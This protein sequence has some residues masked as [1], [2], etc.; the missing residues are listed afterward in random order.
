MFVPTDSPYQRQI[1]LLQALWREQNRFPIGE[2]RGPKLGSRLPMPWARKSLANYLTP[3][4]GRIVAYEYA[5]RHK[6]RKLYGFPRLFDDLLSSQPLCF[7]LFG[8]LKADLALASSVFAELVPG[9]AKVVRLEFEHS[10]GRGDARFSGD[11]SA[12][13][14]YV[15]YR[16]AEGA[17]GFI[18][19]EVKYHEDLGNPPAPHR[20]RYDEVASGMGCFLAE[21]RSLLKGKPLQQ[22]WRDHLLAGSLIAA[23]KFDQGLFAV[24]YPERNTPCA[25]AVA[26]YR[27]CLT[28]EN[29]FT[30]WTLEEVITAIGRHT[31]KAWVQ[32]FEDRYLNFS[33]LETL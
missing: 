14:V 32:A 19:I 9:L 26:A 30:A 28:E 29:T 24:V 21:K 23:K 16:R 33:K 13:D 8:E 15:E 25:N 31:K 27:R 1:R 7:N 10:P 11:R 2:H 12:F 6:E 17:R 3:T 5:N 4:I 18:G 20:E 22:L